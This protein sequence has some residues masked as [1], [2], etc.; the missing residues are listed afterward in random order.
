MAPSTDKPGLQS[1]KVL[2]DRLND[3]ETQRPQDAELLRSYLEAMR[4]RKDDV[5]A[6]EGETDPVYLPDIMDTWEY[7]AK[8]NNDTLMSAV[9]VVLALLIRFL[10][11]LLDLAP[12]CLGIC[13]TL[14][15]RGQLELV[16]RNLGADKG[17]EFVISPTLRLLR[18]VM[19]VDG[20]AVARP[21]F[22]ARNYTFRALARNMSIKLLGEG[23]EDARHTSARTNAVR[24]FLAALQFLHP[25]AK[26]ELLAQREVVAA[27]TRTIKDDPPQ[28]VHDILQTLRD[29]VLNDKKLQRSARVRLFNAATLIRLAGLYS[30]THDAAATSPEGAQPRLSVSDT[31]HRLL[32]DVSTSPTAGIL[33]EQT[34]CY[35]QGIDPNASVT[36]LSSAHGCDNDGLHVDGSL[37]RIAWMGKFA[38]EVPVF[39]LALADLL[40]SL[41]P[42]SSTRQCAL[43]LAIFEAAPELIARYFLDKRNFTFEPKISATW[44]GFAALLFNTIQVS[45]PPFFG[46]KLTYARVPP[47]TLV[48]VDHI[49]PRPLTQKILARCLLHKSKLVPFFA[50]RLLAIAIEK[51]RAALQMHRAAA[52]RHRLDAPLWRASERR[53]VDDFCQ[54]CPPLRDVISAYRGAD[55]DDLLFRE[56]ASRVMRLYYEVV[57]QVAVSAKFDV[58]SSLFAAIQQ[59]DDHQGAAKDKALRL[60]ELEHLLA[61]A[62]YSPG[63]QWLSKAK[64]LAASPFAA[65]L[66]V[67]TEARG[68]LVLDTIRNTLDFV[69]RE[70]QLVLSLPTPSDDNASGLA[71]L[72][73]SLGD[74]ADAAKHSLLS[75]PV[76]AFVDNCLVR[77]ATGPIKYIEM[78]Q[79]LGEGLPVDPIT[80]AIAEQLRF[81][82]EN[83]N[84]ETLDRLAGF[85]VRYLQRCRGDDASLRVILDR[86]L[87][88]FPK[89][90]KPAVKLA[91][92]LSQ[93]S[94]ISTETAPAAVRSEPQHPS[95]DNDNDDDESTTLDEPTLDEL[96]DIPPL[97]ALDTGALARWSS[98]PAD[99]LVEEGHAAAV[100]SLLAA[101]SASVRRQAL[102]NLA[103]MA[104]KVRE[105]TYDERGPVWLLLSEL[106][107]TAKAWMTAADS[108]ALP[109][110][111]HVVAFACHAL[112]VL[113]RPLHPLYAKV[114]TFLTAGPVWRV[115]R[116]PYPLLHEIV[117][118]GPTEDDTFYAE[119][120]W[121]L[122]YLLDSLR[123]PADL[124]HFRARRLFETV[125]SLA[126]NPYMRAPL[127][128]QVLRIVCRAAA[129]EGGSTTLI[130]RAGV[131]SWLATWEASRAAG[132]SGDDEGHA[133]A[134][135]KAKGGD[136]QGDEAPVVRALLRRLWDTCDQARVDSWSMHGVAESL[137]VAGR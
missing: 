17:K 78:M 88:V 126:A 86:V 105:S 40:P 99:E 18:E 62:G 23:I 47:P 127:R 75:D 74:R 22:R 35:P 1:F 82:T 51:L 124:D 87:A 31:A 68:D 106:V 107:E 90:G 118:D 46:H 73:H 34:G 71:A 63:M 11:H 21:L 58:S 123:T 85:L 92:A 100:I 135:V 41:R 59:V 24:F 30:Y 110:P 14:L 43:V 89:D 136:E 79:E 27:L 93:R 54:R 2:L 48:V 36:P 80:L 102:V 60:M 26:A 28:L 69:A 8:T 125:A 13:R 39:N 81:A 111:G 76:W 42:W 134:S 122:A 12:V 132:S 4:P 108:Q 94:S 133:A 109:V 44:V 115:A 49:L 131:V 97:D 70:Q 83:A 96:L 7:A 57:P 103:T 50:V 38:D 128:R 66:K 77:C 104:A 101:D 120:S 119:L 6:D 121:L 45:L 29:H 33:R 112:D 15:R 32:L 37:D 3:P 5:D 9:P 98:K 56:A 52:R 117:R 113:R 16:A 137:G 95:N 116:A 72:F 67:Y 114:N 65:L 19:A 10:S 84:A 91:K 25:E 129:I 53:A 20:G 61:I 55:A 64:G 130:T